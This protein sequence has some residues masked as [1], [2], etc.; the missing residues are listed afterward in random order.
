VKTAPVQRKDPLREKICYYMD[1]ENMPQEIHER[2]AYLGSS[3]NYLG[4]VIVRGLRFLREK[5]LLEDFRAWNEN[6]GPC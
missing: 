6:Q 3:R 4:R 2:I 1:D 5:R